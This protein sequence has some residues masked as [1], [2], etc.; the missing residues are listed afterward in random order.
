MKIKMENN[1]QK[2]Y[3]NLA[4]DELQKMA[5]LIF[6]VKLLHIFLTHTF[7]KLKSRVLLFILVSI[8]ISFNIVNSFKTN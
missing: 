5:P 3:T 6:I 1:K 8:Q 4:I 7:Y 2:R